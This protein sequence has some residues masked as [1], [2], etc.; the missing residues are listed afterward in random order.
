M[1][2]RR[3]AFALLAI[4]GVFLA[5]SITIRLALQL[6]FRGSLLGGAAN[7][8]P[9]VI[10]GALAYRLIR[11]KLVGKPAVVQLALHLLLCVAFVTLSYAML[12]VLLGLF[13]GRG[14]EGFLVQPFSTSGT[15]W[16]TLEN[17]TTYALIATA[18][19]LQGQQVL[20]IAATVARVNP[21][22]LVAS[23]PARE[24]GEVP[25]AGTDPVLSRYFV[26][27]GDELRPL[28]VDTV[29][30]IGGADDYSEVNT[31]RQASRTSHAC[32]I[33]QVA[34]SRAVR[35]GASLLDRE[36]PSRPSC[37]VR[38][39]RAIALAHG[40]W[41]HD[42]DQPGRREI[43]ARPGYLVAAETPTR[44]RACQSPRSCMPRP[45]GLANRV[46]SHRS[47]LRRTCGSEPCSRVL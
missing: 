10:F 18:S 17:V 21:D 47:R 31:L 23:S 7:T 5:Y 26:R 20:P 3:L 42:L 4:A 40:S 14:P 32:R 27:I 45:K 11:R 1:H 46:R 38:R 29:V 34:R 2:T 9:V 25:E 30:S 37:R 36:C 39:R 41:P 35:S 22:G 44:N 33:R 13:Y 28:D 16:Q 6:D 15:A 12:I 24:S 43:A 8:V 19:Y